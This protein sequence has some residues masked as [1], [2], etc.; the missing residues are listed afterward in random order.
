MN[1]MWTFEQAQAL[2]HLPFI[3]LVT[4]ASQVH[5]QNFKPNQVQ[6]STLLSI[7]TGTCPE[8]CSY[9][10]QS[11]HYDTGLKKQN[12]M[13]LEEVVEAAKDAKAQG[14]TRFCMGAAWRGPT[15]KHL[16]QVCEMVSSVKSL[17]LE[18]CATLGLLQPGQAEKLKSAGLD[19]YNH[20]IDTSPEYY[21]KVITTRNF[22]DRLDTL[23]LVRNAGLKV[24]CGG[25]IGMGETADD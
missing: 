21:D 7:K 16:E 4:Q 2:Y 9:C 3:N 6:V 20:N 13:A 23:Q 11:G 24:C 12:L 22:Q 19:F 1:T 14:S 18:T 25:I 8:N 15:D 10:P 5:Q 17:G